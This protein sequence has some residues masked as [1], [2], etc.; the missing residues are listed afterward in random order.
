RNPCNGQIAT[1]IRLGE[2]ADHIWLTCGGHLAR[3]RADAAFPSVADRSGAGADRAFRDWSCPCVLNRR[4]HMLAGDMKATD[5][6]QP[7]VVRFADERVHR[8]H[9]VVSGLRQRVA[10]DRFHRGPHAQCVRQDDR[11]LDSAELRDLRR[12]S[13]FP[14]RIADEDRAGDLV[15]KKISAVWEDGRYTGADAIALDDRRVADSH[16]VDICD[17]IERRWLENPWGYSQI[18][19][20]RPTLRGSDRAQRTNHSCGRNKS[21]VPSV[22][23]A[24]DARLYVERGVTALIPSVQSGP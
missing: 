21:T 23:S 13:Q 19:R 22:K 18:S 17:R 10:H 11:R 16:A 1:E 5:V 12:A 24:H 15:L 3:G 9:L 8:T 14:K 20:A 2:H 4:E 6:V 7:A